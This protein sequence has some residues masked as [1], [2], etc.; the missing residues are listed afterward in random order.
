[1][2][3]LIFENQ[4]IKL[5]K[6]LPI[7]VLSHWSQNLNICDRFWTV[8]IY[9][10]NLDVFYE[11]FESFLVHFYDLWQFKSNYETLGTN[12]LRLDHLEI[13]SILKRENKSC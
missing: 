7:T 13:I 10:K 3:A 9:I 5:F 8:K 2:I 4:R 1:M 12:G 6:L 11:K